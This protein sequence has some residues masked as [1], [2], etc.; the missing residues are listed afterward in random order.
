M[1]SENLRRS[2][3]NRYIND[4][5]QGLI[6]N[7]R[8]G[9]PSKLTSKQLKYID[10]ALRSKPEDVGLRGAVWDGKSLSTFIRQEFAVNLSIRQCQRLFRQLGFRMRKPRPMIAR[11]KPEIKK[12]LKKS[13]ENSE[14]QGC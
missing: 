13:P 8:F 5:L 1:L 6:E 2:W 11:S 3:V 9:R 14:M 12:N 10:S 4:G 7:E